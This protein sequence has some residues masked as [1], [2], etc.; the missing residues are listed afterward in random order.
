M[1]SRSKL[2]CGWLVLLSLAC[3]ERYQQPHAPI[4]EVAFSQV[5]VKDSF[6]TPRMERNRMV[7]LP[8]AYRLFRAADSSKQCSLDSLNRIHL[9]KW[10]EAASYSL[11][12]GYD[13]QLDGY[14]DGVIATLALKQEA[15]NHSATNHSTTT[16]SSYSTRAFS[17]GRSEATSEDSDALYRSA[18]LYEAA[19]AHYQATGKQSLLTI[20]LK[21]ANWVCETFGPNEGQQHV[22]SGHPM[23]EMALA[24]LYS[25][26]GEEKYLAMATYFVEERGRGS[27]GHLLSSYRQD[28]KPILWQDEMVGDAVSAGYLYAGVTDVARL[29]HNSEYLTALHRIWENMAGKKLYI[30]GGVGSR[31]Q[32]RAFGLNYELNNH[33]AYCE[34]C[35]SIAQLYW[36]YRLFLATGHSKYIDLCE[37]VLYNGLLAG[38]SLDG[39]CFS[40]TNPLESMGQH[41]R[42]NSLAT[43]CCSTSMIRF[44][45]AMPRYIYATQG[46]DIYVNLYLESETAIETEQQ[47]VLVRQETPYP[48]EGGVKLTVTPNEEKP[49]ALRLRIPSWVGGSPVATSLYSYQSPIAPYALRVN[50]E[51]HAFTQVDGYA[52]IQREWKRGDVVELDL[53]M[54]VRRIATDS[55]VVDNRGKLAMERGPILYCLEGVDQPDKQVLNKFIAADA[56]IEAHYEADLLKGVVLLSGKA[57]QVDRD[58]AIDE[59]PFKAIPYA[60]WGNRGAHEMAVWVAESANGARPAPETTLASKATSW[61]NAVAI[62]P[63]N[64]LAAVPQ[65]AVTGVNDQWEPI[66]SADLSKPY[67]CWSGS[68][69]AVESITYR[70]DQAH[71]VWRVALY[72]L[73]FDDVRGDYRVPESWKLYYLAGNQWREVEPLNS[74]TVRKDCYNLVE[75]KPVETTALKVIAQLQLGKWGGVIE[76]K[77]N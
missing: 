39:D 66:S 72:W 12:T 8:A 62:H 52:T 41:Q 42:D 19:V 74:Y 67:H 37:R 26:T 56:A 47:T 17:I 32:G 77:V 57:G 4:K 44:M 61:V 54:E 6:W 1:K 46:N 15:D 31:A 7:L 76:W 34:T 68:P 65:V 23:I 49:F 50:G 20:A 14:V 25:V 75:C 9:Y 2:L 60:T 10:I 43:L 24:K 30:T 38:V 48:W 13:A 58:G 21:D 40:T 53:P 69:G 59:V 5:V 35:A 64:Q 55:L 22:P 45:A 28:H 63:A 29:T 18:H 3:Q 16:H 73:E 33:T 51:R 70:F 71:T 11:A 36:N 27:D